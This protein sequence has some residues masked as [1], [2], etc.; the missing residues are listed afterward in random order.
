MRASKP[1][2]ENTHCPVCYFRR[3]ICVC[4]VVPV[5]RTK[6]EILILR[7][8][9][10]AVR[11]ANTG[12]LAALAMPNARIVSCGGGCRI[13]CDEL[14]GCG[15]DT[16]GT[17]LLWP[18]GPGLSQEKIRSMPPK[19]LAVLDATWHQ[20]RRLYRQTEVL[21]HLPKLVLSAPENARDRLRG[22]RRSDGMSTLEAI[23]AAVAMLEGEGVARPL[24]NFYDE[25]VRRAKTLR[26]GQPQP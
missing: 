2:N 22:Q 14:A 21:H 8:V 15:L 20:A 13:G 10:E 19:R 26:W 3:E 7:H 17:W 4:P 24:E 23:A 5:V 1:R 12:R 9:R 11:P 18:D 16:P 25:V 6:T